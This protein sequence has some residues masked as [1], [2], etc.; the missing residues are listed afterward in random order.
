VTGKAV[1]STLTLALLSALWMIVNTNRLTAAAFVGASSIMADFGITAGLAG[2]LVAAYFPAYGALQLPV[3]LLL[4]R[5]APRGILLWAV[6]LLA[7]SNLLFALAPGVEWA[8]AARAAVGLSSGPVFLS[9]VKICSDLSWRHYPRRVGLLVTA[10]SVGTIAGLSGLPWMLALWP[11]RT[12]ALL[13]VVPVLLLLPFVALTPLPHSAERERKRLGDLLGTLG[14]Q[15]RSASFWWLALPATTWCGA[16]FGVLAWLPRF[17]RDILQVD[18]QFTG[19]LPGL[20]S[21]GLLV[22]G[23]LA[24]SIHSRWRP[25][26]PR[27]FYGGG[28]LFTL[29]V[30]L[31]PALSSLGAGGLLYL[32][33]PLMGLLFG[34]FF[35]WMGL[36]S[37][38]VPPAQLGT[39]TGLLNGL[40]FVPSFV[41]PWLTG[42][43]LD[44]VDRPTIANPSY[45][46]AAYTAGFLILAAS[47][48]LGLLGG[49]ICGRAGVA[50]KYSSPVPL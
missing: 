19:V 35:T 15:V 2:L 1:S 40:T 11:W 7:A 42:V 8:I 41:D 3:G 44:L 25:Q 45:S 32:L 9:C 49:A 39:V 50:A 23:V 37:E 31:L 21:I 43:I 24:G 30:L 47:M 17:A 46:A 5:V 4:D 48:A 26:G 6:A 34:T 20:F 13:L 28:L 27:L 38:L 36:I 22:G 16:Y 12:V 10:G 14:P 29:A 33:A 18:P